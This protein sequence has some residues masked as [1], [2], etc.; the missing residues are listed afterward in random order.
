GHQRHREGPLGQVEAKRTDQQY[1]I[2][3]C[4]LE[5]PGEPIQQVSPT[6]MV[7][8]GGLRFTRGARG[9]DNVGQIA[10]GNSQLRVIEALLR[11]LVF[12]AVKGNDG[13]V[14]FRKDVQYSIH[15]KQ[16]L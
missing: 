13:T 15:R 4:D 2:L 10:R 6:S 1:F 3:G 12:V 14:I 16:M 7:D 9:K 8:C 11:D 5:L